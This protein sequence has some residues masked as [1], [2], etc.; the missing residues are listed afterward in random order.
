MMSPFAINPDDKTLPLTQTSPSATAYLPVPSTKT[1]LELI[2]RS[3]QGISLPLTLAFKEN[4]F[5]ALF[6]PPLSH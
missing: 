6:M 4:H 5:T 3:L 2:F 1:S